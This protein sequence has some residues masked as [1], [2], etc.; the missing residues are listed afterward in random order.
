MEEIEHFEENHRK[1]Y[2]NLQVKSEWSFSKSALADLRRK[3]NKLAKN[4]L[5]NNKSKEQL[6]QLFVIDPDPVLRTKASMVSTG[7][8]EDDIS[9]NGP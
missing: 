6:K 7:S 3:F 9:A 2:P 5:Q 4:G 1:I 8:L